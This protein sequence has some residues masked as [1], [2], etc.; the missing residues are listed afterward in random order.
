MAREALRTFET[1]K[2]PD[3]ATAGQ[4]Y[5]GYLVQR[6]RNFA[7]FHGVRVRQMR[8]SSRD[9]CLFCEAFYR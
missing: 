4:R 1:V 6:V 5:K 9:G 7:K 2:V 3:E 8:L